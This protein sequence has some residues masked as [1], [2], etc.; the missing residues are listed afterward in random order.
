MSEALGRGKVPYSLHF[1][2]FCLFSFIHSLL[3]PPPEP[4]LHAAN[5][6]IVRYKKN[7]KPHFLTCYLFFSFP[8]PLALPPS[9]PCS[10]TD[11][12]HTSPPTKVKSPPKLLYTPGGELIRILDPYLRPPRHILMIPPFFQVY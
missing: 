9:P 5:L 2:P 6:F 11:T 10:L 1:L 8:R 3:Y 12:W 7:I 4:S